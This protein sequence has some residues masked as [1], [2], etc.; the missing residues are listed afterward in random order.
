MKVLIT[1]GLGFIGCNAAEYFAKKGAEIVIFDNFSRKGA[2]SNLK[3][4]QDNFSSETKLVRG[5]IR[6]KEDVAKIRN[7]LKGTD[8]V[9]HLAAQVAVTTSV[10]NPEED[11]EINA[12]GTFN[13]LEE[14]RRHKEGTGEN[15]A[16]IYASTNKVY[17]GMEHIETVEKNGTH[18]YKDMPKGVKETM[19]LDFH[20]PYGCSK[21]A[22]DQYVRDYHRIYGL[23]T[24]VMRQSC[25]YGIR[26]FGVEDQGWVAWFTIAKN[27]NKSVKI[28]GDGKQSRDILWIDD[29]IEAYELATENIEK[30]K[31]QCYNIGGGQNNKMS[32]LQLVEKLEEMNGEFER[33]F[34]DWRPGDQKV[35]VMNVDKAKKDFGWEPKTSPEEG[36]KKLDSW[37]KENK[38]EIKK[39]F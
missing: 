7:E 5:D 11:F 36:I 21:G 14:V 28:Y 10:T 34:D 12:R 25:I 33:S 6:N 2:E 15:P 32:I 4:L 35:C 23:N 1:G 29:L 19:S 27:L 17:G 3:Y 37:V 18:D 38:E 22:G 30:T 20:S 16:F 31:G 26:Q 9:L 24:V 39:Y 13:L 8:L